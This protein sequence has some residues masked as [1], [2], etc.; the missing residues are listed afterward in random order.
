MVL[1]ELFRFDEDAQKSFLH[2][3]RVCVILCSFFTS[4]YFFWGVGG[5]WLQLEIVLQCCFRLCFLISVYYYR[6]FFIVVLFS[7]GT[8]HYSNKST[9]NIVNLD[10]KFFFF[11]ITLET[12]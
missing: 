6:F 4:F 1:K 8:E 5:G 2:E 10:F 3:V 9:N 11:F 7:K 12:K